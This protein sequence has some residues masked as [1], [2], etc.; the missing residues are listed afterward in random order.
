MQA[1]SEVAVAMEP[2]NELVENVVAYRSVMFREV[3]AEKIVRREA[4]MVAVYA[5]LETGLPSDAETCL[6]DLLLEPLF[7]GFRR[8]LSGDPP[9]RMK[10]FQVKL[11]ANAD[12]SK[13][14]AR[15]RVCSPAKTA[16]LDEQFALFTEAGK[17][18]TR[19][20]KRYV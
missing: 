11:K 14:K 7:N 12:L 17:W 10:H 6:R 18:C 9:A 13:V 1:A 16:W 5:A 2:R 20:H 15:P 4:L 8:S 3:G 19:I